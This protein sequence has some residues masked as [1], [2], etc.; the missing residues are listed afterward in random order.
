MMQAEQQV[1]SHV[2]QQ[3]EVLREKIQMWLTV[4]FKS[5]TNAGEKTRPLKPGPQCCS[6]ED[7][8]NG[9][10]ALIDCVSEAV[11]TVW[12]LSKILKYLYFI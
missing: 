2:I 11:H 12:P 7:G 9:V 10:D 1:K 4:M 8:E 6:G 5:G 3:Q